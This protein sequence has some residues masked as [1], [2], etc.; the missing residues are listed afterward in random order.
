MTKLKTAKPAKSAAKK[1]ARKQVKSELDYKALLV[2]PRRFD[3]YT[4]AYDSID[5]G[6][7]ELEGNFRVRI[8]SAPDAIRGYVHKQRRQ[9]PINEIKNPMSGELFDPFHWSCFRLTIDAFMPDDQYVQ[10]VVFGAV[11]PWR[12]IKRGDELVV[13]AKVT[14][15][16]ET[17]QLMGAQPI[18]HELEGRIIPIYP[19]D[20]RVRAR[21]LPLFQDASLFLK[22]TDA[23]A[24]HIYKACGEIDVQELLE[25]CQKEERIVDHEDIQSVLISLHAPNSEAEGWEARLVA[26]KM[27][28]L[29]IQHQARKA[30]IRKNNRNAPIGK[31][32]P[33]AQWA[34][35]MIQHV[36]SKEGYKLTDN[37]VQVIH[38][39]TECLQKTKP[40]LGLLNGEVGAGKTFAY[41][42]PAV[43]AHKAGAKVAIFAPTLLLAN[44]IANELTDKFGHEA[45]VER[46]FA[47]DVIEDENA[48]LVGTI[49]LNTVAK[50]YGYKPDFVIFDEQHKLN[51]LGRQELVSNH[52]HTLEVTATPIPRSLALSFYDGVKLFE[53]SEQPVEKNIHTSLIDS[54]QRG[55]ATAAIKKSMENGERVAVVFTLVDRDQAQTMSIGQSKNKE[56]DKNSKQEGKR[57]KD[58]RAAVE[59]F[60]M[61]NQ[62]FP[63][64]VVLLHGRM[65]D[66]EK[67]EALESF[68]SGEKPLIITTTIF[69]TGID[70]PDV[71]TLVIRNP[72]HL[73]LSQ[74]HQLRGRLARRGGDA[75]CFLVCD[76]LN[77]LS[78]STYDRLEYFTHHKDGYNLALHDMEM[79]GAGDLDGF[80]QRGRSRSL[81][82]GLKLD[83]QDF[84]KTDRFKQARKE[85]R[86]AS[87][88]AR[89]KA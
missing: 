60:E 58:R 28:V 48:I 69:E 38:E 87:S 68:R 78:R 23:A 13:S 71:Q 83:V 27:S 20:A 64:K 5:Y 12:N 80:Q 54:S 10:I 11:Q 7:L 42:V 61:F 56:Q 17:L 2:A 62:H 25:R 49:G 59:S 84:L 4:Y 15:F 18:P 31:D 43:A 44:Q 50:K 40:L 57:T 74:L 86:K 51:T 81:F 19:L 39:I 14:E 88:Q 79:S 65:T 82:T 67:Q 46:V 32:K 66:D 1:A 30:N 63:G 8:S 3:D 70:V 9:P 75:H 29:A 72:D 6:D 45:K 76:D 52:T 22:A 47:G 41:A 26:R 34:N 85:A 21:L 55:L 33:M 16:R 35:E 73:G 53:L 89:P 37:Q 77:E 36:E 24:E